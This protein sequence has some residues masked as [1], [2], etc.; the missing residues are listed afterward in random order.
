MHGTIH[1]YSL[2]WLKATTAYW[3]YVKSQLTKNY[4][5][6]FVPMKKLGFRQRLFEIGDDILDILD[7]DRKPHKTIA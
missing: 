6:R 5:E 3:I 7:A 2:R 1:G 4:R